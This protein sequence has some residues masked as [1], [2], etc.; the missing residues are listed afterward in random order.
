M[1]PSLVSHAALRAAVH[2][3]AAFLVLSTLSACGP[4]AAES[5]SSGNGSSEP[6]CPAFA[7]LSADS[8]KRYVDEFNAMEEEDVVNAIP[9]SGTWRWM[10]RN[11]PRFECPDKEFERTYYYRWWA[12]R[13]HIR[14]R[15]RHYVFTEFLTKPWPIS[16]A[17]GHVV[18]EG[19][20]LHDPRYLDQCIDFYYRVDPDRLHKFSQ[21]STDAVY[22]RYLVNGDR[23]FVVGLL[24]VLKS[25]YERW[26]EEKYSP[27][28][29]LFLQRDVRDAMEESISGSRDVAQAR[30]TI[31]SYMY[32]N[33]RAIAHIAELVGS[34]GTAETYRH[35]AA[36]LKTRVQERLWNEEDRF[37]EVLRPDGSHAR[38][39]E[40]IGFIP[41][42]FSLP[43]PGYED[44]WKQLADP[45]GF[46]A[47]FGL[48]TA[49]RRHP[50][51]RS[52]GVGECEW[53]GAVWPYA[54]AQTLTA[55]ANV[56][57]AY[58]QDH[59]TRRDYFDALVAYARC[60]RQE[61]KPY[62]GEYLGEKTGEW[63]KADEVRG[64]HYLHSTFADLV[65]TGVVGLRPREDETVEVHPLLPDDAWDSFCLDNVLYH[66]RILTILWD[67]TGSAYGRG[68]GLAV[69][70]DGR[71]I[72]R[73][74]TLRPVSGSME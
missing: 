33:A 40:A 74:E 62:I 34:E 5:P 23:E 55:L 56:L 6:S 39:R 66:G 50:E 9:N 68:K 7:V 52:H 18:M 15:G 51:F 67:R 32:G 20:W 4:R 71:E 24:P 59:A 1:T 31:N 17:F 45:E 22:R 64:R 13:K 49:E 10:A 57:N 58:D 16:S 60:Q 26:E 2:S 65:V 37:F 70:V 41:W 54:T 73:S 3:I 29:G 14:R 63:I 19:R 21:W 44:A 72:V 61:G 53:D 36:R 42:Y 48:T 47:P 30:P 35:K 11:V 27:D 25:D 46:R 38:V 8:F 12:M 28:L 69:Y 43:D